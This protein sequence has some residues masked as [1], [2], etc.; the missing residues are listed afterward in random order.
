MRIL[1]IIRPAD[2][3][4]AAE[5]DHA[6]VE[7]A[8]RLKK[9]YDCTVTAVCLGPD[10]SLR[11]LREAVA[12]GCDDALLLRLDK[13]PE[14]SLYAEL[15]S[16]TFREMDY[17][18]IIT[19]CFAVDAD[20]ISAG[21]QLAGILDLPVA[22]YAD[23]IRITENGTFLVKR[24]FEDRTQMLELPSPCLISALPQ[25]GKRIYMTADG[26]TKAYSM[27]IPAI[28]LGLQM[29]ELKPRICLLSSSPLPKQR[30]S[31]VLTVSTEEAVAAIMDTMIKNH[32]L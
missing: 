16:E 8:L 28:D 3:N 24:Q 13:I 9:Q 10:S 26:V 29:D 18:A 1:S 2:A 11:H 21:F 17:Q 19:S 23:E 15:L 4:S 32:M 25:P 7:A 27:Q 30:V 6:S 5:P 22:G 31:K 12:M 20:T 14:P